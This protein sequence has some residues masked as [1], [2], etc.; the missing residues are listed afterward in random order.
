MDLIYRNK[1]VESGGSGQACSAGFKD[2]GRD[3]DR[4]AEDLTEDDWLAGY[5]K[6]R[7]NTFK[8]AAGKDSLFCLSIISMVS[9]REKKKSFQITGLS[10]MALGKRSHRCSCIY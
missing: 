1:S 8:L 5:R 2:Q 9:R 7:E 4:H 10:C 3:E 6:Q